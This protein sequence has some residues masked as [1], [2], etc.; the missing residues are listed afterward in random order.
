M[1]EFKKLMALLE[2]YKIVVFIFFILNKNSKK[3]FFKTSFLLADVK[4]DV[5]LKMSF[6]TMNNVDINF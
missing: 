4:P 2:T 1:L 3:M 5:V 6:L